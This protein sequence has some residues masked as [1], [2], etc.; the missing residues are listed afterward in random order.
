MFA[1]PVSHN[2]MYRSRLVFGLIEIPKCAG[3]PDRGWYLQMEIYEITM[4]MRIAVVD[5]DFLSR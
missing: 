2:Y 3:L 5:A 1:R 4:L